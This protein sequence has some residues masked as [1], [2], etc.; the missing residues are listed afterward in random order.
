MVTSQSP[1]PSKSLREMPR[2]SG[3][4]SLVLFGATIVME[5]SS[6]LK[7]PSGSYAQKV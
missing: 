5:P 7:R 3:L 1:Y 6:T 2:S 4:R